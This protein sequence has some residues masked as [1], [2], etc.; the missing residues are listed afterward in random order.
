MHIIY[1]IRTFMLFEY[2]EIPL[3]PYYL[4]GTECPS[5][6]NDIL[7]PPENKEDPDPYKIS[8]ASGGV[9]PNE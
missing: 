9:V 5:M 1:I 4:G 2:L 8:V 7:G 6:Y 3:I